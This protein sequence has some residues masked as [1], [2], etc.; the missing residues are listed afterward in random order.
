MNLK[1]LNG[2]IATTLFLLFFSACQE[3]HLEL[4][5]DGEGQPIDAVLSKRT[6][7]MTE[8]TKHL[9]QDPEYKKLHDNCISAFR[10][11]D[12]QPRLKMNCASPVLVPVAIHY[13][14]VNNPDRSCLRQLAIDQINR[15]NLDYAGENVDIGQWSQAAAQFA[16]ISNGEMCAQFVIADQ[17]HPSGHGLANGDPA[18]TFNTTQGD[19]VADWAGYINI[20]VQF[21]TGVLGYSPLGGVGNGDG[22]VIDAVGFGAGSG[23]GTVAP[24]APYNLGRTLTHELGHYLL[25]DHI[26]GDGCGVDDEVAD[27]PDQSTDYSGCPSVGASSCGSTDMHMNYMD[28]TNDACM[29]MFSAGQVSRMSNYLE[30]SLRSVTDNSSRVY[31]G[32]GGG[33]GGGTGSGCTTPSNVS[34]SAQGETAARVSWS[35][36]NGAAQYEVRYRATGSNNYQTI[37]AQTSPASISGLSGDT[38]YETSVRAI[39][40]DDASSYSASATF[41][42]PGGNNGGGD[43]CTSPSAADV[44]DQSESSVLVDWADITDAIRYQVRYRVIGTGNWKRKSSTNSQKILRDLAQ[45]VYEYQLRTRCTTG[46]TTWSADGTF[47]LSTGGGTDPGSGAFRMVLTLDDYGSESTWEIY[48]ANNQLISSDGPFEDGEAG[49]QKIKAINL[50][51]GCYEVDLLDAFGDGICCEYGQGSFEVLDSNDQTLAYSDGNFGSYELIQFCVD[52]GQARIVKQE[53]DA[54]KLSRG[55]K[56]E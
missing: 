18:I 54:K 35:T 1:S 14:G 12:A 32:S 15:V 39:C 33:N 24:E 26:W 17:N 34:A 23:C 7:L 19:H 38:Q 22:V 21:N 45:D 50:P 40:S 9:L 3:D 25:L 20:F 2:I 5:A 16:N 55:K 29:Y 6:C 13:Q 48:D 10:K 47:D 42:T 4:Y 49:T 28:Y 52:N 31:S 53:R 11:L 27:T 51:D 41:I 44:I 30:A 37:M 56:G 46:W 36:I 8:H 43:E